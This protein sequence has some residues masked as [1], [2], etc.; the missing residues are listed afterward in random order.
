MNNA[1]LTELGF[2]PFFQHQVSPEERDHCDIA[3]VVEVQR[4]AITVSNG[5]R[6]WLVPLT[7]AWTRVA[8]EQRPTVGDWL[9]IEHERG[10]PAR[11]LDRKSVFRRIAAGEKA[12]IQLIASNIDTLFIVTSCNDDFNESRLERYVSLAME[13]Q[14]VPVIVVTKSD[15]ADDPHDYAARARGIQAGIFVELVNALDPDTLAGVRGWIGAGQTI[16]FVGSSGVG[17]STLVNTLLARSATRTA[18]IR[19]ADSRGRHTTSYRSLYRLPDGGLLVDVP[20]MRE[21]RIADVDTALED[22]FADI[23]EAARACRFK[24]CRHSREPGCAVLAA[25]EAGRIAPRR[26][27]SYLKLQREDARNSAT[28][29]Q[30]HTAE[31]KLGKLYKTIQ[32]E[33]RKRKH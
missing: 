22:V 32:A 15:L 20:G 9:L 23:A 27:R 26:L 24:D 16:A 1:E 12:Q 33:N 7:A 18:G 11:I 29:A 10:L 21:L 14:V 19:D 17:K 6:E 13:A 5:I 3:R 31:K 25:V 2:A 4:S 28:L 30:R 8:P